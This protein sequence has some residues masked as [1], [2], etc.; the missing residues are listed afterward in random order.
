MFSPFSKSLIVCAAF[1]LIGCQTTTP[2]DDQHVNNR[3][4][5]NLIISEPLPIN[6]KKEIALA[7]ISGVISTEDLSPKQF[8]QAFYDRGL[9]YDAFGLPSLARIDFNR[10]LRANPQMADAYNFVGVH[11]TLAGQ[12]EQAYE[13]FDA[14]LELAPEH[15]YVFLNRGISLYYG[16][17]SKLAARDFKKFRDFNKSDPYRA[18][19]SYLAEYKTDKTI[20]TKNLINNRQEIDNSLWGRQIAD[21]YLMNISQ[22]QFVEE[23]TV[24]IENPT[25]LAERLCEAYFYLGKFARMYNQPELAIDY[26]KLALATNVFE[27]IEHRYSR[28]ELFEI[29]LEMHEKVIAKSDLAKQ[30]K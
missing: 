24:G 25:Q 20:A 30:E 16:G 12:F 7:R 28:R 1:T 22:K 9:L 23:L 5:N 15:E 18:V 27:F 4:S 2:T 21:L 10:A 8:A 11:Y 17:D 13:A 6:L 19:W 29:R 14:T 3:L 26:F